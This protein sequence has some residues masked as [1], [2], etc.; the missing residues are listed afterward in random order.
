MNDGWI[1]S[2]RSG[3]EGN[4]VQ[5]RRRKTQWRT[6]THSSGN[7]NCVEVAEPGSAVLIRDSKDPDGGVL[8]FSPTSWSTFLAG[9]KADD[10][11]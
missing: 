10:F 6:S 2:S 5:A 11:A 8:E 7:G 9:I 1:T 3:I 4:C